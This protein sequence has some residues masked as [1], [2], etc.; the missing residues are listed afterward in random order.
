MKYLLICS[1]FLSLISC[2]D[3]EKNPSS[4]EYGH[5][6]QGDGV[7]L[8]TS[9]VAQSK[10]AQAKKEIFNRKFILDNI[11][12]TNDQNGYSEFS[13]NLENLL[14][15]LR[16]ENH[17]EIGVNFI[18][19]QRLLRNKV[20]TYSQELYNLY[21]NSSENGLYEEYRR[22]ENLKNLLDTTVFNN[23]EVFDSS[24]YELPPVEQ[25]E[26]LTKK[27]EVL[28]YLSEL[29]DGVTPIHYGLNSG[30]V[31]LILYKSYEQSGRS[32]LEKTRESLAELPECKNQL[33]I[34]I[35]TVKNLVETEMN[36]LYYSLYQDL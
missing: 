18:K 12:E 32:V 3:V 21:Y 28:N 19:S 36:S 7:C 26:V 30:E 2:K 1:I 25:E 16:E 13:W 4:C 11:Q 22:A 20:S 9:F 31:H 33:S 35:N 8:S 29:S 23:A 6:N 17:L 10:I 27:I 15:E 14:I 5:Q 24:F 34:C